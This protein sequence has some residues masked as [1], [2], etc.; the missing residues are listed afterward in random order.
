MFIL[1]IQGL[2]GAI[3][4]LDG[5]PLANLLLVGQLVL[6]LGQGIDVIGDV[7]ADVQVP[8]QSEAEPVP[9]T[10]IG[11]VGLRERLS[12]EIT[13]L[14]NHRLPRPGKISQ[15]IELVMQ[16]GAGAACMVELDPGPSMI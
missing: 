12:A 15:N 16:C 1:Q 6:A 4:A 5:M 3:V 11:T 10:I 2:S 14:P 7:V 13:V 9:L 8:E